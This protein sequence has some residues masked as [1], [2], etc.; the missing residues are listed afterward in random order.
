MTLSHSLENEEMMIVT[1]MVMV[2]AKV[3]MVEETIVM[4]R[5]W[6]CGGGC[7]RRDATA[8]WDWLRYSGVP[9]RVLNMEL[10]ACVPLGFKRRTLTHSVWPPADAYMCK[11]LN[12]LYQQCWI[13]R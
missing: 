1:V 12:V 8:H 5:D 6:P 13:R 3:V 2:M 9:K 10:N 4:V 7:R 11:T